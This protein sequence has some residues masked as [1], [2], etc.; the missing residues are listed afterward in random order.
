[1]DRKVAVLS[2]NDQAERAARLANLGQQEIY[3][4]IREEEIP[5]VDN[6]EELV[7]V[8]RELIQQ[9]KALMFFALLD[10]K[11]DNSLH[12]SKGKQGSPADLTPTQA[13]MYLE[14]EDYQDIK[15]AAPPKNNDR[16]ALNIDPVWR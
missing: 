8:N 5:V 16:T 2:Y 13:R 10:M 1:M 14:G 7:R 4:G 3:S 15:L 6:P 11:V 9:G 12:F